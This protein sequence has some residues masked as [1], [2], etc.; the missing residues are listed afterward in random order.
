MLYLSGRWLETLCAIHIH[1]FVL[2]SITPSNV[3]Q[4]L[5]IEENANFVNTRAPRNLPQ[6]RRA[7]SRCLLIDS[8]N[9]TCTITV[10]MD[11][12]DPIAQFFPGEESVDLYSVLNLKSDATLDD[13]KKS[14]RRQALVY[15]PD[16]HASSSDEVK[17]ESSTKFQQIGYAYAVLSDET[18]RARYDRTGQT[19]EGFDMAAG[20]D[21]WEAYF[22]AMFER[23]TK[24]K[25][26]EMKKNYQGEFRWW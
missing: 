22:E 15:H 2:S 20:E 16:K 3:W 11:H 18:R 24:G 13:I 17:A 25:L 19:D 14:Y 5:A 10:T 26:D 6:T 12:E 1:F 21:G 4:Q 7:R 9:S 23:V 8:E